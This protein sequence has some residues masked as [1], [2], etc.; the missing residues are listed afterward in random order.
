MESSPPLNLPPALAPFPWDLAEAELGFGGAD[1]LA[2]LAML[3]VRLVKD[4]KDQKLA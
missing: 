2:H 3:V 1:L 4:V